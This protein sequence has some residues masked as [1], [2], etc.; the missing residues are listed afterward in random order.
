MTELF[1]DKCSLLRLNPFLQNPFIF[2]FFHVSP[3]SNFRIGGNIMQ[4][5]P[6]DLFKKSIMPVDIQ[7]TSRKF[8][9][10]SDTICHF[11]N[12]LCTEKNQ[13]LL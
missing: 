10:H 9:I 13:S 4:T 2:R 5:K 3:C 6:F 1:Y 7:L 8:N 11:T 12:I